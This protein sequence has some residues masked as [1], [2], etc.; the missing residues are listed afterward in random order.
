M[1]NAYCTDSYFCG[2]LDIRIPSPFLPGHLARLWL[3]TSLSRNSIKGPYFEFLLMEWEWE[4]CASRLG[5]LSE[6]MYFLH[7]LFP[8]LPLSLGKRVGSIGCGQWWQSL[9]AKTKLFILAWR[10]PIEPPGTPVQTIRGTRNKD[11]IRVYLFQQFI[12]Y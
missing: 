2:L 1:D 11:S 5:S 9:D 12:L 7:A 6:W 8:S 3:S 10:R 4:D